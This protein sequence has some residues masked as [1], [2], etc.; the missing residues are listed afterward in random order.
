[1]L[2]HIANISELKSSDPIISKNLYPD[3]FYVSS[4]LAGMKNYNDNLLARALILAWL[5]I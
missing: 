3:K 5:L 1:M 4:C 2:G